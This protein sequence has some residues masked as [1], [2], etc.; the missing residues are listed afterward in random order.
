MKFQFLRFLGLVMLLTV[1]LPALWWRL[2]HGWFEGGK[3]TTVLLWTVLNIA[4]VCWEKN[5]DSNNS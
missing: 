3:T 2:A 4:L 1:S 5:N